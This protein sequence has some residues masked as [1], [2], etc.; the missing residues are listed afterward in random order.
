[1]IAAAWIGQVKKRWQ[2]SN[3][4]QK[5]AVYLA[6]V[7]FVYLVLSLSLLPW[8]IKQQLETQLTA[9]SGHPVTVQ[10]VSY[11]PLKMSLTLRQFA[12]HETAPEQIEPLFSFERLYI[13][14]TL[15]SL[16]YW[17]WN[18]EKLELD[19][20]FFHLSRLKNGALNIDSLFP[21]AADA[22]PAEPP[23]NNQSSPVP[24]LR[25]KQFTLRNAHLKLSDKLPEEAVDFAISEFDLS[26]SDFYTQKT[27]DGANGYNI[28]AQ[29]GEKGRL[30][31]SGNLDLPASRVSGNVSLEQFQLPHVFSFLR[32]YTDLRITQG[33]VSLSSNYLIDYQ[34]L[35]QF[36]T[37]QG[38][39]EITDFEVQAFDQTRSQFNAFSLN[40][41]AFNLQQ[42]QLDLGDISLSEGMLSAS[43]DKHSQ[44][45][46]TDWFHFEKLLAET[47]TDEPTQEQSEPE[48]AEQTT[49]E[50]QSSPWLISLNSITG[51]AFTLVLGESWL[52]QQKTHSLSLQ[53]L[54][55]GPFSSDMQQTTELSLQAKLYQASSLDAR[56]S[57]LGAEQRLA[58]QFSLSDLPLTQL[59]KWY[60]PFV[61]LQV[62]SGELALSSHLSI[63]F[64]D[65][66]LLNTEQG[67]VSIS[68]LSL[69][70]PDG[71]EQEAWL[72]LEALSAQA[73][74]VDLSQQ[75]VAIGEVT[76]QGL[77][78][79]ASIDQDGNL[80]VLE[81]LGI[82]PA[83]GDLEQPEHQQNEQTQTELSQTSKADSLALDTENV[84]QA[85]VELETNNADWLVSIDVIN[86][87]DSSFSFSEPF[88]GETLKHQL[89]AP[90]IIVENIASS[91]SKPISL[92]AT[93]EAAQGGELVLGGEFAIVE[94]S[95]E[96]AVQIDQLD[97][98]FY[99]PY[100]AQYTELNMQS[101][102]FST[103]MQLGLNWQQGFDINMQGPLSVNQLHLKDA[104]AQADLLKWA[105]FNVS[106][107]ALNTAEQTIALGEL[108]FI[109][110]Y[111]LIQISEDFS[112]NLA[113][114]VKSSEQSTQSAEPSE[115]A[116]S[117][118]EAS[119]AWQISI[120]QTQFSQGLVD[121]ADF[122]LSPNFAA[123]I[124][125]VA[126]KIGRL[127]QDPDH[128]A[129]V[130]LSGEVDGY[131]PVSFAGNVAPLAEQ[132]AFDAALDF[133]HL[134]LTRLNAY[135]GTYAGYV[136]ERGQ[137]SLALAYKLKQNQLQ[138]S[139][140]V[141]IE[142]LQLGKRTDSDKATSLPVEL[143]IALLEDDQGVIDLGLEVSGDVND[144]D[145]NVAGLVF[146]ALGGALKKIITSPFALIGSLIGSD[147]TLNQVSFTAGSSEIEEQQLSQLS[148]LA[149]GLKKRP[150]L[151]IGVV[152][153][154]NAAQ[155]IPA[156]KRQALAEQLVASANVD[157]PLHAINL[158][159]VLDNRSLRTAMVN[160]AQQ[161]LDETSRTKDR[162]QITES[163][164]EQ[165]RLN[166]DNLNM[167][168]HS[169]WYQRLVDLIELSETE[170]EA[171]A[172]QRAIAVKDVLTEQN[173][174]P[175][176]RTFVQRQAL[177]KQSGKMLVTLSIIAD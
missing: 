5:A 105:E 62:D 165:Q 29:V 168:L 16:F 143:A 18:F 117:S 75:N 72:A 104:R 164:K 42:Q 15:S 1:M 133:K 40:N 89:S 136:I 87:S 177:D 167:E 135:S 155:D 17:S 45:D 77:A 150:Q 24:R 36:T 109:Q 96:L 37:E 91:L 7:F 101:A 53:Q 12:I 82:E 83:S 38:S 110:P 103:E 35:F 14:F 80:D 161:Q 52:G 171:F 100:I 127:S 31:W 151:K 99:Q 115:Q 175:I 22:T 66:F 25:V 134:E 166:P 13:D 126:G 2:G 60:A 128:P 112:T 130:S 55:V 157:M 76:S 27:G 58:G 94:Q 154:I 47:Q 30:A 48:L 63:G 67:K 43:F 162:Q 107:F 11:H 129:D 124:E 106:Q 20:L 86:A 6:A 125:K 57:L 70:A 108:N 44:L 122:S 84:T 59:E 23:A 172:E 65:D 69:T 163:L 10:Q 46:W 92:A 90:S 137:M 49:H 119:E 97:L 68:K 148:Q 142:Q 141:Y 98:A 9:S 139:N 102:L 159:A 111:F 113:G 39:L 138:G 160:L 32:P 114:I 85:N 153:S 81:Q 56:F 93:L 140:Q 156:L 33:A 158:S 170:L 73:I 78:L 34:E 8:V 26:L 95:A 88:S 123:K 146:K 51:N 3:R 50:P 174:L 116:V 19:G 120:E 64:A 71:P 118:E 74:D 61:Q 173:G 79:R 54:E 21:P 152:G 41:I 176:D 147:D 28:D 169:L 144:P 145:F 131:A 149:E 4:W 132:P 121:F